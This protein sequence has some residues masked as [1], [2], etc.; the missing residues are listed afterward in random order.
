MADSQEKRAKILIVDDEEDILKSLS[1]NLEDE[2]YQVVTADNGEEVMEKIVAH[3]PDVVF[4]DI[5]LPGMDGIQVLKAIKE[6]SADVNVVVMT[7]HGTVSTAVQATKLGAFDFIEKPLDID[8]VLQIINKIL[9]QQGLMMEGKDL[10]AR[11]EP[12]ED[13]IGESQ[14]IG[15]VREAITRFTRGDG[16]VLILGENGTGQELVARMIHKG[17]SR[18]RGDMFKFNCLVC[19]EDRFTEELFGSESK[20]DRKDEHRTGLFERA[21][22]GTL[23]IDSV[24]K[25]PLEIQARFYKLLYGSKRAKT[26]ARVIAASH[27]D[28]EEL[29]KEGDFDKGFLE[30]LSR[31]QVSLPPLRERRSDIP[32]LIQFFLNTVCAEYGRLPKE[33]DDDGMKAL[34]DFDWPGNVKE[35][36]NIVER[37]VISVPIRKIALADIPPSI[38]GMSVPKRPHVYEMTGSLKEASK[39]WKKDF[40]TFHLRRLN[41]DLKAVSEIVGL[42]VK[43][44]R[45]NIRNLGI[46]V[47]AVGP[48]EQFKQ[49]TLKRSV[50]LYGQGLHSGLKT[51]LILS[52]LPPDSGIIF[53]NITTEAT[54]PID[55]DYIDST[56]Y[57]TCLRREDAVARTIEHF[58]AVLHV[59]RISNLMV[60]IADEIPIMDGSALDFCHLIEDAGI[61]EQD[62]SGEEIVIKEKMVVGKTGKGQKHISIEPAETFGVRYRL[63]YPPPVGEQTYTFSLKD[64]E[65]FKNE[66][67]PARTFGFVK[68]IEYLEKQ[69]LA[70]GGR[71]N[72]FILIDDDKIVNTDLRF[73][74][75]LA[76]HKILD[77]V[78]D[79]YLLGRPIRGFITAN[80]TGHSENNAMMRMIRE[81]LN[82][83]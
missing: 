41:W 66:I 29:A 55:L 19:P 76:R 56:D 1:G 2:G 53:G 13:L 77:V 14:K 10:K 40:L 63:S 58:M 67:A 17:S 38:R 78:G 48:S 65:S 47:K 52:P 79:F 12:E 15:D 74:D 11:I 60:K 22:G 45:T 9:E 21:R 49:R 51:G 54:V 61:E 35:L 70:S 30:S 3:Q 34:V 59:Y 73:P 81:R 20:T 32:L 68:D 37:L 36:R 64:I 62:L 75:E 69:G 7:G 33:L 25:M 5:W 83:H 39:A 72:N 82:I 43:A 80:M 6:F 18:K 16:D 23:F 44:L 31:Y 46:E 24:E 26:S 27:R 28:L 4:L 50:V 42:S 8:H 71:L 57:A